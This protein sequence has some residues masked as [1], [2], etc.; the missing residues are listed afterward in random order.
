VPV[1]RRT[2]SP[3]GAAL[4]GGL[5]LGITAAWNIANV[6]A[7]AGI[8]A[9]TYDVRLGAV[10][11]LTTALFLTHFAVQIPGGRLIDRLGARR[12]GL[13]AL[14]AIVLGNGL[15][16]VAASFPLALV[17]RL[18]A[19]LGTGTGFVAGSDYIRAASGSPTAQGVYGGASVGGSGLAV[20]AVALLTPSLGWRAPYVSALALV[21]LGLVLAIA[22]ADARRPAPARAGLGDVVRDRRLYPL[23][24]IH[25]ASFGFSVILGNWVVPL[26]T[27]DGYSRRVAGFVGAL[28]L[29]G[30]LVTRPLGGLVMQRS[31]RATPLLVGA[32]MVAGAAGTVVVAAPVPLPLRVAASAVVGLAAGIP[33]AAAFSGAA[34]QRADAPAAAVGLVNSSATLTIV[35]GAPLVGFAFALPGHGRVGFAV[36]AALW[37]AAALAATPRRLTAARGAR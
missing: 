8:L 14:A 16:I 15:A 27:H 22:P 1:L 37:V 36:I 32:S 26:L 19:G 31:P 18:I 10:G 13:G 7:A 20:A 5:A 35:A 9:K 11:F 4:S 6:G 12:V 24:A 21:P 2:S 17:G 34:A 23:A 28:T 3:R 33:F 29:L 30:G 25:T